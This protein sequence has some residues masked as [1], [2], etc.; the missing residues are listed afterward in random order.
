M[1]Q[2]GLFILDLAEKA[3]IHACHDISAGGL[4]VALAEIAIKANK[5]LSIRLQ[6]NIAH[7]ELFGE[8]QARYIICVKKMEVEKIAP[9]AQKYNVTL[10]PLGVVKGKDLVIEKL[11]SIPVSE[12]KNAYES[13]LPQYMS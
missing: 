1:K 6:T 12:L 13:W 11:F 4:A 2:N 8:D 7:A 3:Y 5:G 10:S 9:L